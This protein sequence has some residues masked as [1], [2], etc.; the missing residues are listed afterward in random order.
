M[1]MNCNDEPSKE[2]FY[3]QEQLFHG[4]TFSM[5]LADAEALLGLIIACFVGVV[6]LMLGGFAYLLWEWS[7]GAFNIPRERL[8]WLTVAWSGVTTLEILSIRWMGQVIGPAAHP[9]PVYMALAQKNR[10]ILWSSLTAVWWLAHSVAVVVAADWLANEYKFLSPRAPE[11]LLEYASK[12]AT[13]FGS[14]YASTAF[15]L[16]AVGA[17]SRSSKWLQQ[18]WKIRVPFDLA[19]TALLLCFPVRGQH[20]LIG[21]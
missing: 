5:F 20:G 4:R 2:V 6:G 16:F 11:L 1:S 13:I 18:L 14:M 9:R 10:G 8:I 15:L 7:F 21:W 19:L 3:P 12:G 17:I